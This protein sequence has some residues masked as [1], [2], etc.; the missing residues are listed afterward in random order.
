VSH[1]WSHRTEHGWIA[2]DRI[3]FEISGGRE[4]GYR[5]FTGKSGITPGK[6]RV[7]VQTERG[8]VLGRIDFT[9]IAG[10]SPHPPL[11]TKLIR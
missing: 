3:G 9:V 11:V 6:W 10:S 1:I 5:G 8:R 2:T 7:E 4:G